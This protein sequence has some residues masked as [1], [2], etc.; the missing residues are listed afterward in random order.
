[1]AILVTGAT[2]GIGLGL[3]RRYA[4]AG[5]QV[6]GTTRGAMPGDAPAV[7]WERLDVTDPASPGR[8]A[9]A[10]GDT[11]LSL[12]VCN[13]GV[14]PD[15]GHRLDDADDYDARTWEQAFAVNVTGVFLTI[16]AL[17]PALARAPA[18]R[19][20]ILASRMGSQQRAPGGSLAYRASKAAAV[21]L[22]RNLAVELAP[23]GIAVG[24]FHPGWVRTEMGGADADID[25]DTAVAG[26]M[27]RFEAL[28]PQ[29][30]GGFLAWDGQPI[31]L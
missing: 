14:Y 22:G 12:L 2:R 31:P 28:S 27:A 15:K 11:A 17:L 29:D 21:N 24:I 6:I 16:R 13:A 19:I 3:V 7:R 10:L 26:L 1:V 18:P 8:L 9:A 25:V 20:A 30:T 4:A 5:R 23:R